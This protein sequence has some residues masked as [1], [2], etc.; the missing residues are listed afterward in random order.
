MRRREIASK[1]RMK[2][3]LGMLLIL[4]AIV[5]LVGGGA[6]IW[7]LSDTAEFSRKDARQPA[8]KA[9]PAAKKVR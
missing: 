2:S 3:C 5:L 8:P 7:Y 4:L 9:A 1:P 6:A